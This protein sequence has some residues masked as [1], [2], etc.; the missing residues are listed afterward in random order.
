MRAYL[1]CIGDR[2]RK[3]HD[4]DMFGTVLD[5]VGNRFDGRSV[6]VQWDGGPCVWE[7][8]LGVYL[9]RRREG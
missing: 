8:E 1:L 2:V 9:F 5:V 3:Q 7:P 4:F 6:L